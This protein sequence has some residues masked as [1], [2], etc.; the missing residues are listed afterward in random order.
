MPL[1]EAILLF[2][3]LL[4][5]GVLLR[6][7]F[8][9]L[10]VPYTVMLVV[11][12]MLLGNLARSWQPLAPLQYF[13]LGPELVFF[14]F[15]PVLIFESGLGLN[16]RQLARDI[17][18]VLMMAVPGLLA[19]TTIIGIGVWL[20]T[21]L[22]PATALLFGALIS[23]TD[24]VAVIAI[25]RELGTPLRLTTLVE[26]ESLLNDATAIVLYGILLGL[27]LYGGLGWGDA[28][29]AVAGFFKVF[30]GG[31]LLGLVFGLLASRLLIRLHLDASSILVGSVI[32]A[33]VAFICAEEILHVSGVMAVVSASI[34]FAIFTLPRL[35]PETG[36]ALHAT[37]AFL[38]DTTNTLLFLLIG[39]AV[40]LQMLIGAIDVILA[41]SVLVIAARAFGV[42]GLLPLAIRLFRLPSVT[43]GER[44]VMWW[45][46]LKGG[47]AIAIV[48]SVPAELPGRELLLNLVLGVVLFSLL[49]NAT[50]IRP[51]IAWLGMDRLSAN[52]EVELDQAMA[53]IRRRV[54]TVLRNLLDSRLLSRAGH[55]HVAREVG[56]DL[57]L[58]EIAV[59]A[60]SLHRKQRLDTLRE[61]G[62]ELER[63]FNGGVIPRYSFLELKNDLGIRRDRVVHSGRRTVNADD[64][65]ESPFERI[66]RA[67]VR[68]LRESNRARRLL[69][70]YQN[71]RLSRHIVKDMAEV[72][73]S[74][75]A[76]AYAERQQSA[77][78]GFAP[79]I[80][81]EYRDRMR[82]LHDRIA[83]YQRDF[84]QVYHRFETRFAR[85]AALISVL[86]FLQ[87]EKASRTI[88]AKVF[89]SLD[90]RIQHA[91]DRVPPLSEPLP[92]LDDEVLV[93]LVP[94]FSGLSAEALRGIARK[95]VAVNY[96]PGDVIIGEG[97]QGDALYIIVRGRVRVSR[98]AG[99][100]DRRLADL[101]P[102]DC[103]GE[104]ALLG[105]SVRKAT[106]TALHA[107]SLLR[108]SAPDVS[109]IAEK[110]P[111]IGE[112]LKRLR[113]ERESIDG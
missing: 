23:A 103:F 106:V 35:S 5:V 34:S 25:F 37:W 60:E 52:E 29:L 2:M 89:A 84:E 43:R 69:A 53:Q 75:A 7:G 39:M 6:G 87:D 16:A 91:L 70:R 83:E 36:Q 45:G 109:E 56:Q 74:E 66:E 98:T 8:S 1:S 64:G 93:G 14:V 46:G 94:L 80:L 49:V 105:D 19:S 33:Y 54:D 104:M 57:D 9:R 22:E 63:L 107:C 100:G 4:A 51:L 32:L 77:E 28:G 3:L 85:R 67:V 50:T 18:P 81:P 99:D 82:K 102:G 71:W 13:S 111:E 47:L 110:F 38:A 10:P 108:L 48:L 101:R 20:L 86:R 65:G 97:E 58:A 76:I 42:Y 55:Y 90:S 11:V 96:L 78:A 30:L 112:Y 41:V 31:S 40:D 26:G 59:G 61:E 88:G 92:G 27:A 12:G 21:P 62:R 72:L 73:M 24:P 68:R 79:T 15:L 44:H 113:Q 17:A 95:T